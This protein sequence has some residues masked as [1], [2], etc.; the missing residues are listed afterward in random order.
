[1][2]SAGCTVC[3]LDAKTRKTAEK[4]LIAEIGVRDVAD[5]L[6]WQSARDQNPIKISKSALD[7]HK[8]S[9]HF[10]SEK[11][12]DVSGMTENEFMTLREYASQVFKAYQKANK[13]KVPSTKEVLDFLL[14]DA[15]LADIEARRNEEREL[16]KLMSDMSYEKPK[17]QGD[18][19]VD[20]N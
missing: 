18:T 17:P 7:R 6:E 4:L 11:T 19:Q 9:G 13:G 1:M 5:F 20:G 15:K 2:P 8:S 14:A 3:A 12:V 10:V 16:A